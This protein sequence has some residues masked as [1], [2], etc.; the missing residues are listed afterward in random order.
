[1]RVYTRTGDKGTSS[2][3][4]GERRAKDDLVFE[5]LGTGDELNSFVGVARA[6]LAADAT[7]ALAP[8]AEQLISVQS[9][10]LDLGAHVAT[11]RSD[12]E[13]DAA[14]QQRTLFP[15]QAATQ[16]EQWI[17]QMDEH[18]PPL[19][20][21]VLPSGGV[22]SAHLHVCRSVTRRFERRLTPLVQSGAVDATAARYV[23]RLSDYF[24]VAARFACQSVQQSETP[25]KPGA[26][27]KSFDE[28]E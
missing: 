12:A 7:S 13:A 27:L 19:T 23:N 10:L 1:M 28:S 9:A 11:P 22:I 15:V 14:R 18:L 2:L 25:Y 20:T 8:L 16:L 4:T 17:D 5:A 21:F 24:F 26:F 6:A 3:Y